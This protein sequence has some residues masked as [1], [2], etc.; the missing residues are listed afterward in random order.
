MFRFGY[1]PG[2]QRKYSKREQKKNTFFNFA[3][4]W[5]YAE[6]ENLHTAVSTESGVNLIGETACSM[7]HSCNKFQNMFFD[8][9]LNRNICDE[10]MATRR[11]KEITFR[12]CDAMGAP[13]TLRCALWIIS[14]CLAF[15]W[16][17]KPLYK[18]DRQISSDTPENGG[19][20]QMTFIYN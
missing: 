1:R 14:Q 19:L 13:D 9:P 16:W 6:L 5:I 11:K 12:R 18:R 4:L 7:V 3:H 8:Q 15:F 17:H 2:N 10:V 20:V